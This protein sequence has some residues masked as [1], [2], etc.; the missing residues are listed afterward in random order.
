M[1]IVHYNE[2][3]FSGL[4]FRCTGASLL[5]ASVIEHLTEIFVD[6]LLSMCVMLLSDA[7]TLLVIRLST[8]NIHL[9]LDVGRLDPNWH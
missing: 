1:T 3:N 4:R 8:A 9:Y 2:C 5:P 6:M 7:H